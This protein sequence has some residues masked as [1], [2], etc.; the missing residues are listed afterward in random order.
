MH[1]TFRELSDDELMHWKYI[2]KRKLPNGKWRYIY[3]NPE[4]DNLERNRNISKLEADRANEAYNLAQRETKEALDN[5]ESAK[6]EVENSK[7]WKQFVRADEKRFTAKREYRKTKKN[8][9][10]AK[11][12]KVAADNKFKVA[13]KK[14]NQKKISTFAARTIEKGAAK[15][16][17]LFAKLFE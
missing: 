15:V 8:E 6:T 16:M 14:Y 3:H 5:V 11:K 7:G 13:N 12:Q 1:G 17:N 10:A 4:L 2:E 9:A